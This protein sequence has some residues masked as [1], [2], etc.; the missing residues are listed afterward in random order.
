MAMHASGGLLA[1][2][3]ADRALFVWDADRGFCS[4]AFRGHNGVVTSVMFHPDPDNLLVSITT[5]FMHVVMM[6]KLRAVAISS[7]FY[8]ENCLISCIYVKS[9]CESIV[10][11]SHELLQSI[12]YGL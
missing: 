5:G 7:W 9:C 8:W 3:G 11:V 4:H 6:Y 10:E 1:T 12:T 2:A